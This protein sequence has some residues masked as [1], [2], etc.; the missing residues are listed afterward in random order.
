MDGR[1]KLLRL[2]ELQRF[3]GSLYESYVARGVSPTLDPDDKENR[4]D[5]EWRVN[6]YFSVGADAL[7]VIVAALIQCLRET[8]QTILDFP[9]GSGRVTRHLTAFFPEARVVACDLYQAHVDFCVRELG[10]AGM[11]SKE[12]FDDLDLNLQFDL[13][14]SGSLLTHLPADLFRSALRL[15]CRSLSDRGVAIITLH[16]RHSEFFQKHKN[17][18]LA[19]ELFAIA[20]AAVADTGFGY[21]DYEHPLRSKF[22]RQARYGI[23]LARPHWSLRLAEA[24]YGIRILGYAERAWDDHHDVLVLGKPGVNEE[25]TAS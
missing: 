23:S 11:I 5:E 7:R 18:Y 17:K 24:D 3:Y 14:F 1:A 9:C 13:I 10:A 20:A 16:S 6:H 12:K 25:V 2:F 4:F 21:V 22:N 8:P 15:I 19:D